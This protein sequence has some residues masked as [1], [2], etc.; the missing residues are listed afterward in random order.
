M[1]AAQPR[2]QRVLRFEEKVALFV[3]ALNKET[4]E[5]LMSGFAGELAGRAKHFCAEVR[6]WDS[7]QRQARLTYEFGVV[8]HAEEKLKELVAGVQGGLRNAVLASLP[9]T[10]QPR[11]PPAPGGLESVPEVVRGVAVRLVRETSRK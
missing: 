6:S 1:R 7:A 9:Q 5:G 8:P 3:T 10:M 4:A 11:F 2:E